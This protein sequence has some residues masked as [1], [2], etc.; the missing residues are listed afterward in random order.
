MQVLVFT[1]QTNFASVF[2]VLRVLSLRIG[3]RGL[4]GVTGGLRERRVVQWLM[5]ECATRCTYK[6][7]NCS[8]TRSYGCMAMQACTW[9][10]SYVKGVQASPVHEQPMKE[11]GREAGKEGRREGGKDGER[12]GDSHPSLFA[13]APQLAVLFR[14]AQASGAFRRAAPDRRAGRTSPSESLRGNRWLPDQDLRSVGLTR[15]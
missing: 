12:E 10:V 11:G 8:H 2:L 9:S 1:G 5:D 15:G 14:L 6:G 3:C 13:L 7:D 4:T